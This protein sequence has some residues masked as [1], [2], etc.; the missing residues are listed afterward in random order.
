MRDDKI[1]QRLAGIGKQDLAHKGD[2]GNRAFDIGQ[3]DSVFLLRSWFQPVETL[4][5]IAAGKFRH[6]ALRA[7]E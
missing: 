2:V 7:G 4:G 1:R 5:D 3:Y 6:P